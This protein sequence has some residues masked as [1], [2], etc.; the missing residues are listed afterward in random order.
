MSDLT[1]AKALLDRLKLRGWQFARI[2]C[3]DQDSPLTG[4]RRR[5]G[6]SD[7]VYINGV[8]RDC[9]CWRTPNDYVW[10]SSPPANATELHRGDAVSVLTVALS[11]S[12]HEPSRLLI[13]GPGSN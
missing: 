7:A 4:I 3:D 6:G 9:A 12:D 2:D 8:E 1:E 10:G 11:W 13:P 5:A